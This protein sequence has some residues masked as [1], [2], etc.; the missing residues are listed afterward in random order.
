MMNCITSLFNK[1]NSLIDL[2]EP[3]QILNMFIL[4]AGVCMFIIVVCVG[5]I[6]RRYSN[7]FM[8]LW[9][10]HQAC[11]RQIKTIAYDDTVINSD[12]EITFEE[13]I[14]DID[15]ISE[16]IASLKGQSI[17]VQVEESSPTASDHSATTD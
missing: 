17:E 5:L 15:R 2:S 3:N 11:A 1:L 6:S 8:E 13:T 7:A 9:K 12:N 4:E 16:K 10:M 14:N